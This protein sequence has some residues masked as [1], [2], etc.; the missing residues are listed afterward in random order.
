VEPAM[1]AIYAIGAFIIV[2]GLI[3]FLEFR[4]ID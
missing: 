3:N 4:R 2:L 1:P